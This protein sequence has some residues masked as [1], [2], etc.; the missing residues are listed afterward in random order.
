MTL[1]EARERAF[2]GEIV[3]ET[4]PEVR[5]LPRQRRGAT[6][7]SARRRAPLGERLVD[8]GVVDQGQLDRGTVRIG[9]V[10]HLGR[11]FDRDP[12]VD[13]D[14]VLVVTESD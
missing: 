8:A 7:P 5:T 6:T 1:D 9:E 3:F 12:S 4:E 11:L 2:T 14:A 10:E 13:R